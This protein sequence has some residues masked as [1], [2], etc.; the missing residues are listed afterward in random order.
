MKKRIWGLFEALCFF[1]A[2]RAAGTITKFL[3]F[4]FYSVYFAILNS[5]D[6]A[7]FNTTEF[8]NMV[9]DAV[10]SSSALVLL[11]AN[12]VVVGLFAVIIYARGGKF[13]KYVALKAPSL[14]AGVFSALTGASLW[15][16]CSYLL[17]TM[18]KSSK[19]LAEYSEHVERS[20]VGDAAIVGILVILIAPII[21]EIV[22]RG[23]MFNALERLGGRWLALVA[24]AALFAVAH[25]NPLHMGYALVLGI[26]LGILRMKTAS[27][28]PGILLHTTFNAMNYIG[29]A[30]E[31]KLWFP[32]IASILSYAL[33]LDKKR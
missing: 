12:L 28:V 25:V 1:I 5:I 6:H 10:S 17:E 3:L 26:L 27:I 23:A 18:F 9:S 13:G 30:G 19:V 29:Y 33:A 15:L 24:T 31:L 22:F 7:V 8:F 32:L 14:R 16:L 4:C 20:M 21:E 11:I 2:Y